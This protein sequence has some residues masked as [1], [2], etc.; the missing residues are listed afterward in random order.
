MAWQQLHA[1]TLDDLYTILNSL[2]DTQ[3]Y[4]FRGHASADWPHLVPSLH[5]VLGS[6]LKFAETVLTEATAIRAFRRHA[7]SLLHPSEM[8]YFDQILDSITLMQHYGAPTRLLDWTLS[9]WVAC[10][11]AVQGE[12]DHDAAVWAFNQDE[13]L[14]YNYQ[15]RNSPDY[16]QFR[17]LESTR[18][19]E[20][21]A[22]A[23]LQA[24]S[25]IGVFRYQ[26]ANPQMSAQQ[27]LF[28]I[29][30]KLGDDHDVALE[31]SLGG[32]WQRL[33]I[34]IS[35]TYKKTLRQRLFTMNVNP[36]ALFPTPDG[37]GRNVREAIQS[38][39]SLGDEGLLWI[40]EEKA[41]P[42]RKRAR[43]LNT[44][45]LRKEL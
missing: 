13:L 14:K 33:K 22:A 1:K 27:S 37:V 25:Y 29:S 40:L 6:E 36:L 16:A 20:D 42:P 17:T 19:V 23:A 2:S 41:R 9:P 7:R 10:Y 15:H 30:G 4:A 11:F 32:P 43:R 34:I 24:G 35:K 38:E 31:R 21:W 5:R 44:R 26:Y 12:D 8:V 45:Q 18:S 39:V 28:T 3:S